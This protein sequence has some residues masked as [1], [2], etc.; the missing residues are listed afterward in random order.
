M[1]YVPRILVAL[2]ALAPVASADEPPPVTAGPATLTPAPRPPPGGHLH[3]GFFLRVGAGFGAYQERIFAHMG[4][5]RPHTTVTGIGTASE[6]MI[7]GNV[8]RRLVLGGGSWGTSVLASDVVLARG[9]G[10]APP[11]AASV[12][13]AGT[14]SLTMFGPFLTYYFD[15]TGGLSVYGAVGLASSREVDVAGAKFERDRVAVGAGAALGVS[16]DWWVGD[17]W[18]VGVSAR[19]VGAT[20]TRKVDGERAWHM[21]VTSPTVLFTVTY[22]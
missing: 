11:P 15:P 8:S 2:C 21:I 18:S 5:D 13:L 6:L 17:E 14:P 1:S 10:G 22:H 20:T 7:G 19:G 4:H 16:Y 9:S 12:D 3:N